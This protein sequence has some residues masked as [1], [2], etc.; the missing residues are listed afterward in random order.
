MLARK[1]K[2]E[3]LNSILKFQLAMA[4]E[5]ENIELD[6]AIVRKG[7]NAVFEDPSKGCYFVVEEKGKVIGS[8]L[9]TY[10]WSD[11]RNGMIVWIQSVFVNPSFR[12]KGAYSTLYLNV[13]KMVNENP[14]LKGIRLYAD[15]SNIIAHKAYKKLGMNSDHYITFEWL[16]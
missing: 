1:A 14:I 15:K 5:T 13:K 4:K 10:E 6:H 3:D 11:W 2:A 7:V 16:K 9:T 12:R 8:L